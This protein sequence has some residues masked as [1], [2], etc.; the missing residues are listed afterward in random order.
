[1]KLEVLDGLI[2]SPE[3][4]Q[5]LLDQQGYTLLDVRSEIE[6]EAGHPPGAWNFPWALAEG[7]RLVENPRF[8]AAVRAHFPTHAGL[9]VACHSGGRSAKAGV[10]LRAAGYDRLVE[11]RHGFFG[12]RDAFGRKLPGWVAAGLPMQVDGA[13][14]RCYASLLERVGLDAA[15]A[16]RS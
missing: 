12:N 15:P 13:P 10:A 16:R 1:M 7:D 11:L 2:V 5:K 9:V 4:A 8:V 3:A 14:A 6:F